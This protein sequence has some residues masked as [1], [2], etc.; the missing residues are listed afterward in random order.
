M[1]DPTVTPAAGLLLG[2]I[3]LSVGLYFYYRPASAATKDEVST[4][5]DK[6]D[7]SVKSE[8]PRTPTH[9]GKDNDSS[10]GASVE[11]PYPCGSMFVYFGSQTG[12]A[13]EF[14]T[15]LVEE[16]RSRG[17]DA[18]IVDLEDFQEEDFLQAP[19]NEA[20]HMFAVA[21]Y[22]EG[23]PTDN[24]LSF[25]KWLKKDVDE[26]PSSLKFCVF[27]LGNTQYEHFNEMGR[28]INKILEDKGAQ[29]VAEYG[30]G[31]DDGTMEE[32]F[33]QWRDNLWPAL[34]KTFGSGGVANAE[35]TSLPNWK[36]SYGVRWMEATA[37][38]DKVLRMSTAARSKVI[39]EVVKGMSSNDPDRKIA[40]SSQSYFLAKE[41]RV[42]SN[43][44]LRKD[45]GTQDNG[46]DLDGNF[47]S[48]IQVEFDL[49]ASGMT[50]A[51]ADTLSIC[52][53]NEPDAVETLCSW[54]DWD[55]NAYFLHQHLSPVGQRAVRYK[56]LFPSPI[57]VRDALL[58][59]CDIS[60]IVRKP[61][62]PKLALY[63][64]SKDQQT[65]LLWLASTEGRDAF[66]AEILIPGRTILEI[67][68]KFPSL[69]I[70][71]GA[72]V[73]LVPRLMARDYTISSSSVVNP[74]I[75]SI[76]CKVLRD[77]KEKS[78]WECLTD[79]STSNGNTSELR[80]H[81]GVCS[82]YLFREGSTCRVYV[83]QSTFKLPE[84]TSLPIIL[85]G[86]GTGIAPMRA[87][88]QE[89]KWQRDTYGMNKVGETDLYFGCRRPDEDYI[90]EEEL[91]SYTRDGTLTRLE[92]GK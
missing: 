45:G 13:E 62:L 68:E 28:N 37:D 86:P 25:Y 32:D 70:P 16:G 36:P 31:D 5:F 46:P 55:P 15:T 67:M 50:Y 48:T 81:R 24:A 10:A 76:T 33:E 49:N 87:F 19:A 61:M 22:G 21:T 1:E 65:K 84:D 27:G 53:E 29:R 73:E 54:Q 77:S 79:A 80:I 40:L 91:L 6:Y 30:E 23:E 60:S 72:F 2:I 43:S 56:P 41:V 39:S 52:P 38:A 64:T 74:N 47:G 4:T 12:T 9:N 7:S 58:R 51:T 14:A 59:Y 3:T 11:E 88:L 18:K 75:C 57:S 34:A 42:V 92:L 35:G 8:R 85:I 89:R 17:F 82:N 90:Y 63:A 20:L 71:F 44:E 26:L 83:K 69:K 66:Q 78:S